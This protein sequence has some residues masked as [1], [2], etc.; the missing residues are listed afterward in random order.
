VDLVVDPASDVPP[1]EQVRA[2]IASAVA[3]GSLASGTRLPTVRGLADDLGLA[4]NTVAR[5]YKELEAD[6]VIATHG[7]RG[8][9]VRSTGA[10][11]APAA[12]EAVQAYVAATRQ[13]GLTC[14][15]AVRLVEESWT[16]TG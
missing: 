14:P 10:D 16:G 6:G 5:A 2:G 9:F 13:L 7:R 1:Y 11:R 12:R 15:E 3:D 8:T 4:P